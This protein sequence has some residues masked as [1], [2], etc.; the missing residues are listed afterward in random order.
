ME[1]KFKVD[2][3][4]PLYLVDG[5]CV[6]CS[7]WVEILC[8]DVHLEVKFESSYSKTL[9]LEVRMVFM[10]GVIGHELDE[11]QCALDLDPFNVDLREEEAC[12][13]NAFNKAI[14][15]EECFLK[16]KA[17]VEWLRVGDSNSAYFHK[18]V[19]SRKARSRIDSIYDGNGV[20]LVEDQV[21][22][23]FVSYFTSF[24]GQEGLFCHWMILICLHRLLILMWLYICEWFSCMVLLVWNGDLFTTFGFDP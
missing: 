4:V 22:N 17:K 19:K 1:V 20:Q 16:Q 5:A 10:H 2:V 8:A 14:L 13:L 21:P 9:G 23:A 12:Y 18:V 6:R 15:K 7:T 24:L 3:K 11:V